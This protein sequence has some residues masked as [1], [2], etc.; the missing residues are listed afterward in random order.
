[1]NKS[2]IWRKP[3]SGAM[4]GVGTL[5]SLGLP[6]LRRRLWAN[7]LVNTY[8]IVLIKWAELDFVWGRKLTRKC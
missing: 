4:E 1:M 6:A 5:I 2:A 8:F 7:I 3:L